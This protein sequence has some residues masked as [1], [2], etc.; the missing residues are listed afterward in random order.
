MKSCF[1][2]SPSPLSSCLAPSK[3]G[4]SNNRCLIP[5]SK[6]RRRHHQHL[7]S[8]ECN[9]HHDENTFES[10][11]QQSES[12]SFSRRSI[13]LNMVALY[14]IAKNPN[15]ALSE[16]QKEEPKSSLSD[17]DPST[18]EPEIT[19]KIYIDFSLSTS[20]SSKR[21][22]VGLYG[23]LL[24]KVVSNFK[25]LCTSSYTDTFIYRI[26]PGLTIQLGDTLNNKGKTGK[27][28]FTNEDSFTPDN[29]RI[30]HTIPGIVSMV[31]RTD[32][33]VDSRFF[34][35][36]RPGDSMYLDG[37]YAGFGRVID[38]MNVLKDIERAG[39]EG[40]IKKPVKIL[41]CGLL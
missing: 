25:N 2:S 4:I 9:L 14:T 26:V 36:T 38:G 32:G 8:L 35:T 29:F 6:R 28:S 40:Y 19:D 22:I 27:S 12:I 39:G 34:I 18:D 7:F 41:K 20:P 3:L 16:E 5:H 10:K 1:L 17:I 13:L 30:K 15:P 21:I 31:K 24:P 37:K 33:T 11:Q 23:N